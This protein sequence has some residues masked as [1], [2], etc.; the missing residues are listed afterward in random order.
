MVL[1]A[2]TVVLVDFSAVCSVG[3]ENS[4]MLTLSI[5][6]LDFSDWPKVSSLPIVLHCESFTVKSF[7]DFDSL[8]NS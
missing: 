5:I 2:Y 6:V 7:S 8:L 1:H 4:C 3:T